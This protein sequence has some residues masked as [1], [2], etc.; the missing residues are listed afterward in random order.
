[1]IDTSS[2]AGHPAYQSGFGN[3][4]AT[5]ALAGALPVGRNSPQQCAYGLYAEQL[6]GTA[7]TA[8]RGANQRSWLY[9]IRPAAMHEPL[10]PM[11]NERLIGDFSALV[12]PPD[13]LRWSPAPLPATPTDFVDGLVTMAGN[14]DPQVQ[15][16]A[17]CHLYAANRSMQRRAFYSAALAKMKAGGVKVVDAD[18]AFYATL[19]KAARLLTRT[20]K[21]LP[22]RRASTARP[23]SPTSRRRT[24]RW[25]NAD[26]LR[27]MPAADRAHAS[28]PHFG[29]SKP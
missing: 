13:P 23:S 20:S 2:N 6:T 14:G 19:Q 11:P 27:L 24:S 8:P 21:P 25:S 3:E 15:A 7:F 26:P 18:P 17:A 1:M 9:R 22:P 28:F 5:E 12:A 16:G 4:F 29:R 10:E